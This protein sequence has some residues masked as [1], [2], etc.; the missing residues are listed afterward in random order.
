ML[1][2]L[3]YNENGVWGANDSPAGAEGQMLRA[4]EAY[5]PPLS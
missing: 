3:L 2:P 1:K 4:I 5:R